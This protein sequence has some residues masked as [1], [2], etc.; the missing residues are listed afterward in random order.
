[1]YA[2]REKRVLR[3]GLLLSV[4][5]VMC[6]H[7]L[8]GFWLSS[9][10]GQLFLLSPAMLSIMGILLRTSPWNLNVKGVEFETVGL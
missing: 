10:P 7:V 2:N 9:H 1:M 3:T 6:Y 5:F 8:K 4:I